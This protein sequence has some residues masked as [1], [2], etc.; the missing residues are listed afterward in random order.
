M[1]Q[2]NLGVA[3]DAPAAETYTV[4]AGDCLWNIAAKTLGSGAQWEAIYNANKDIIKDANMIYVGQV[5]TI[6]AA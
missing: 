4:V 1:L 2:E 3:K 6:P 5:L